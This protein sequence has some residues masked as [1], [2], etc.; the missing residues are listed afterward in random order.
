MIFEIR[1]SGESVSTNKRV[2]S[3]GPTTRLNDKEFVLILASKDETSLWHT[4]RRVKQIQMLSS[5][6][7]LDFA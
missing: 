3:P 7:C 6:L 2:G 1:S 5:D 4:E